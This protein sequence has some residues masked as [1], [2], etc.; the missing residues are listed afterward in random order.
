M[1]ILPS[2]L[3][4]AISDGQGN[5]SV[6]RIIALLIVVTCIVM[7]SLIWFELSAFD[8]KLQEMPGSITG[9]MAAA[10]TLAVTLYGITKNAEKTP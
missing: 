1:N 6:G 7:P 3:L 10:G 9:F 5:T 4:S 2:W 8:N